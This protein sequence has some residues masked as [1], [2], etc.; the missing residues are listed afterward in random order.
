MLWVLSVAINSHYN[1]Y[2][3]NRVKMK[4]KI[5]LRM[6]VLSTLAVRIGSGSM[7]TGRGIL[8]IHNISLPIDDWTELIRF[9]RTEQV[10]RKESL[11]LR[12]HVIMSHKQSPEKLVV[13]EMSLRCH[14]VIK[15]ARA[16][17]AEYRL[18]S[19]NHTLQV[20]PRYDL[21]TLQPWNAQAQAQSNWYETKFKVRIYATPKP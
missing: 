11:V 4:C 19:A 14:H 1:E 10:L 9:V 18:A 3:I 15:R 16:S 2:S 8:W 5:T 20:G 21:L 12:W 13:G 6:I 17:L 7:I